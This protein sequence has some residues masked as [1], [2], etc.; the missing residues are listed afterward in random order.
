MGGVRSWVDAM[1]P[2][3]RVSCAGGAQ[4]HSTSFWDAG[5]IGS[6]LLG[7]LSVA[8]IWLGV[9]YIAS[10]DSERTDSAAYQDTSNLAR[11]FEE[12]IIRLIQAHDQI[13]LFA[14]ASAAN[15]PQ[16]FDLARWAREQ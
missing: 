12:H 5:V 13:L 3:P 8:I 15:D 11:A 7:A 6:I 10:E 2:R 4:T 14:R 16:G 9:W 1:L